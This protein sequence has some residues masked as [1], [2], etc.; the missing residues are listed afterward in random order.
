LAIAKK[1]KNSEL[2]ERVDIKM[3]NTISPEKTTLSAGIRNRKAAATT[4]RRP[5]W[6]QD[7]ASSLAFTEWSD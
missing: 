7:L 6:E 2:K 5:N 3:S 4:V 1:V